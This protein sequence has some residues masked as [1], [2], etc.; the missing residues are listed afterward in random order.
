MCGGTQLRRLS[1]NDSHGA[2][3]GNKRRL[4]ITKNS[5][6]AIHDSLDQESI[7]SEVSSVKEQI[8]ALKEE[9]KVAQLDFQKQIE[10]MHKDCAERLAKITELKSRLFNLQTLKKE[11]EVTEELI[12]VHKSLKRSRPRSSISSISTC[13]SKKNEDFKIRKT[14]DKICFSSQRNRFLDH[15]RAIPA[16]F[17]SIKMK[18]TYENP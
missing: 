7:N 14:Q 11:N 2:F 1:T 10:K 13:S 5:I 3:L 16:M 15:T 17:E 12:V 18:S 6:K 9:S 4:S 8:S